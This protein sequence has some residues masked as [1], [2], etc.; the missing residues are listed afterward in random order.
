MGPFGLL[1]GAK[2]RCD[3]DGL[4]EVLDV[5][6]RLGD[7]LKDEAIIHFPISMNQPMAHANQVGE[8]LR[9]RLVEHSMLLEHLKRLTVGFRGAPAVLS[10]QMLGDIHDGF[11]CQHQ[12]IP[13]AASSVWVG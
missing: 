10:D 2:P 1:S 6:H 13:G 5:L 4:D 8:T 7:C 11:R 12:V 9:E 3:P